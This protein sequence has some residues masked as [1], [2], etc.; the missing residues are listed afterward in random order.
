VTERLLTGF[1]LVLTVVLIAGCG[2]P[3]PAATEHP[4][5]SPSL[6]TEAKTL[7]L[8]G[9]DWGYPSPFAFYS[10]GPGYIRLSLLF[11]TL[12]WKDQ[13][14]VIPWLADEWTVSDDRTAWTFTLHPNVTWHDG[15]PL[16]AEDVAFSFEYFRNLSGAR[17]GALRWSWPVGKIDA[18]KAVDE[19]TVILRLREPVAGAH[20]SL[21]GTLPII[22]KHVWEG[23]D[24]PAKMMSPEAVVGSG[25]FTLLDYSKEEARYVYQ[26]NAD[27]FLGAPTV[28]RLTFIRV[29]NQ[30]LAL[31]TGTTDW[32]SFWGK[33]IEAVQ[34]F[35]G[36]EAYGLVDGP[37]FWV[38][39]M[40]FNTQRAPF[41]DIELRRAVAHAIDRQ[42]IVD[43]VAHGGAVV[44]NPGILSPFT[45]WYNPHLRA[46]EHDPERA[47]AMLEEAGATNLS[48]RLI[49]TADFSREA[50]L[51]QA[52]LE[53]LGGPSVGIEVEVQIGDYSTVDGLLREG[54]FDL[55][56]NGHGGISN[57]AM[58]VRPTW[59]AQ[60]YDNATYDDLYQQQ[61]AAVDEEQRRELVWQL[62]EIVAED[63]PVLT[64][65]HPKM[66]TV[67][68][69]SV[70][71]TW[72]YTQGGVGFGIPISMN[73]LIFLP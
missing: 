48:P 1:A 17:Q 2:K 22:P 20:E 45:D 21:I 64:L 6:S 42:Q 11:D 51:V 23:V 31:E 34:A 29:E 32:A 16:T 53:A 35:D 36:G 41:D 13:D 56:I 19:E 65:Y 30:A 47:R 7:T 46:Y 70:L 39:Q 58:L 61:A 9:E 55:A 26:A 4:P 18:A 49:T 10:R 67:Y 63:L 12:T 40:I 72:F 43:Q 8:P 38:L 69:A 68:D 62:Q 15:R 28:E 71:D 14:G 52:D 60:T 27:Y 44:A 33:E 66:W 50:E 57:P 73:K 3:A 59:P 24:D 25:P 5:T 37:S 54:N